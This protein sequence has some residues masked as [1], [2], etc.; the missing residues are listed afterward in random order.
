MMNR[1]LALPDGR[2]ATNLPGGD[3]KWVVPCPSGHEG[4]YVEIDIPDPSAQGTK[5]VSLYKG[6]SRVDFTWNDACGLVVLTGY[7]TV[8]DGELL[9]KESARRTWRDYILAG[10]AKQ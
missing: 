1:T 5:T 7:G 4:H 3:E 10:W 2:M 9:E 6:I 8:N